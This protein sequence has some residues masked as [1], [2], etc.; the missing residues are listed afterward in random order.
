MII[1]I[2][3]NPYKEFQRFW[4]A[5]IAGENGG[6]KTL[7]ALDLALPWLNKGWSFVSNF[8]AVWQDNVILPDGSM[9][10]PSADQYGKIG[11]IVFADEMGAEIRTKVSVRALQKYPRKLALRFIYSDRELPHEDLQLLVIYPVGPFNPYIRFWRYELRSHEHKQKAAKNYG[12]FSSKLFV[13]IL[14]KAFFGLYRTGST[15]ADSTCMLS[16]IN[17]AVQ[18]LAEKENIKALS[19]FDLGTKKQV[20]ETGGSLS[21]SVLPGSSLRYS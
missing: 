12:V 17:E 4:G 11:A 21:G 7:L 8:E 5:C 14:P 1:P 2:T 6:G 9:I 19:L 15:A 10:F 18:V 20:V 13:Q 3:G 16:W